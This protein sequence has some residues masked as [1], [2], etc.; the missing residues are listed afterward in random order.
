MR[1]INEE[2]AERGVRVQAL[3][4]GWTSKECHRC[5]SINTKRI[6]Q[7]QLWCLYCGLQYNADWN[8]AINIG[9]F[10]FA[11][12]MS[13]RAIEGLAQTEDEPVQKPASPEVEKCF[14]SLR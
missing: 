9:S 7:S 1:C 14:D 8:A 10:F 5:G 11:K 12:R 3:L 6:G 2:C 13:R 4:E